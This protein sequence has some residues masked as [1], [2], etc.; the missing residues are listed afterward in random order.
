MKTRMFVAVIISTLLAAGLPGN[1]HSQTGRLCFPQTRQCIE[2]R[3]REYWEQNGGLPVFG[4][5]ITPQREEI[6]EGRP[7]QTQW[8]ER[9]RFEFHPQN[10]PPYNVLLGLLG[11]ELLSSPPTPTRQIIT[12]SP[13]DLDK[14]TAV[15]DQ[16]GLSKDS[17]NIAKTVTSAL[18]AL[19]LQSQDADAILLM[20][21]PLI[22]APTETSDPLF[23]DDK[24]IPVGVFQVGRVLP[25]S[26]VSSGLP[27]DIYL[28]VV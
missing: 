3:F 24:G 14:L 11:N 5:P 27:P 19:A 28:V 17:V 15:L 10:A 2:G 18:P 12:I 4:Y 20:S 26:N 25:L 13:N 6:V 21:A 8:F 23:G 9:A 16:Y 7:F 1:T 22:K